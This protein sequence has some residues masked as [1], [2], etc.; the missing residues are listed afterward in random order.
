[1]SSKG[2]ATDEPTGKDLLA[3]DRHVKG[4]GAFI[5]SCEMPLTVAV[6]GDWGSG[7]TTF[8]NL[9]ELELAPGGIQIRTEGEAQERTVT[10]VRFDAWQAAFEADEA[11]TFVSLVATIV[12]QLQS[13]AAPDKR[14]RLQILGEQ[15]FRSVKT[16]ATDSSVWRAGIGMV[17][18]AIM[19]GLGAVVRSSQGSP[20]SGE[21]DPIPPVTGGASVRQ[22]YTEFVE[23]RFG[24]TAE[25]SRLV[26]FVDNLDRLRPER[27]VEVMEC[28]KALL[29]APYSIFVVAIDF[30][31][32]VQGLA[33]KYPRMGPDKARSFFDKIIQLPFQV[34]VNSYQLSELL[35]TLF[36]ELAGPDG[37]EM[38]PIVEKIIG[39][40]VGNNPRAI[41][42]L[43]NSY[44]LVTL[45]S[46]PEGC[47]DLDPELLSQVALQVAYPEVHRYLDE[48]LDSAM[49]GLNQI[50][51][52]TRPG[53]FS[54]ESDPVADSIEDVAE[55][56][57]EA[58][59]LKAFPEW[60]SNDR[61]R[62]V[63][64]GDDSMLM[65]RN[66]S[67]GRLASLLVVISE[68]IGKNGAMDS[69]RFEKNWRLVSITSVDSNQQPAVWSGLRSDEVRAR[70]VDLQIQPAV[71]RAIEELL[72]LWRPEFELKGGRLHVTEVPSGIRV[73]IN[74][75][76][77]GAARKVAQIEFDDDGTT[78]FTISGWSF[79]GARGEHRKAIESLASQ[80]GW[81]FNYRFNNDAY[82]VGNVRHEEFDELGQFIV[83]RLPD[84]LPTVP[85]A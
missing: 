65:R 5:R 58:W 53:D 35:S 37:P 19:P 63:E 17:A 11:A 72:D 69:K 39:A 68:V 70:L 48:D 46:K 45:I 27:A 43:A 16:W 54:G 12:G 23:H 28:L 6:Q 73:G 7:K 56:V 40:S 21:Q 2:G 75:P 33:E 67:V 76:G 30:D 47:V 20:T 18:D 10:V 15:V 50:I 85:R 60:G 29:D 13:S 49:R 34:P 81:S 31:V 84:S 22:A 78:I 8:L 52:V 55:N 38:L 24:S 82:V 57:A 61:L 83:G 14:D 71:I 62:A 9:L 64:Q 74:M 59:V 36:D 25:D 42:R 80:R 66:S 79:I 32:V 26:V 51:A 77:R 1:M 41:K 44:K 3:I 4:L